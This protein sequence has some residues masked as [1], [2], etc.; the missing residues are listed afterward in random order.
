MKNRNAR[1]RKI[2][3]NEMRKLTNCSS[4]ITTRM[5]AQQ[6]VDKVVRANGIQLQ[7]VSSAEVQLILTEQLLS[8]IQD[9]RDFGLLDEYG[10]EA[11]VP[12]SRAIEVMEILSEDKDLTLVN[13]TMNNSQYLIARAIGCYDYMVYFED[14]DHAP[15]TQYSFLIEQRFKAAFTSLDHRSFSRLTRNQRF[16][17]MEYMQAE[18]SQFRKC[19]DTWYVSDAADREDRLKEYIAKTY[20]ELKSKFETI[21]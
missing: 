21:I 13:S 10:E 18:V 16:K 8:M 11:Y 1:L 4:M 7:N 5:K 3:L 2:D 12:I 19:Y 14:G 20:P 6:L 15:F 9:A 17:V